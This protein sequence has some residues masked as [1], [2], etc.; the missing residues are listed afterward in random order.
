MIYTVPLRGRLL[1]ESG[2][3]GGQC[4]GVGHVGHPNM[5]VAE[6][7]IR[8]QGVTEGRGQGRGVRMR[9]A[10]AET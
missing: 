8:G 1:G 7:L 9:V 5:E 4:R 6:F 2:Y 10:E 3:P